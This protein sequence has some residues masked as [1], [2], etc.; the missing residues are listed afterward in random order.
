MRVGA[1]ELQ[2]SGRMGGQELR[3]HQGAEQVRKNVPWQ[4]ESRLGGDP[5]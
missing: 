3:Q 2:P 4:E 5:A 1:E